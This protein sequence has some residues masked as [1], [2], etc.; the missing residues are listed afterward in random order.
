MASTLV[1]LILATLL[2][3]ENLAAGKPYRLDP[4][5]NYQHCTDPG[6]RTQLTDGQRVRGYFWTQEGAVGWTGYTHVIITIDLGAV[7]PISGL[8]YHTVAGVAGVELPEA[9]IVLVSDDHKL[10][11]DAGDLVA[12]STRQPTAGGASGYAEHV[13]RGDELAT[14]GR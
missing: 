6:D 12:S 3:T 13:L 7:R 9:V 2:G 11:H 14:H 1:T 4:A 5:P 10:W 8:S